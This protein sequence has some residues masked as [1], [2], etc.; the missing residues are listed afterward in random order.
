MVYNGMALRAP[1]LTRLRHLTGQVES[2]RR[3]GRRDRIT[4]F[5]GQP[6]RPRG[7]GEYSRTGQKTSRAMEGTQ[8]G[9]DPA[10]KKKGECTQ[11]SRIQKSN[12][13]RSPFIS[14]KSTIKFD[15]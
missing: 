14:K 8:A 3:R 2:G 9:E 4:P 11:V 12:M 15:P 1:Q 7:A 10:I 13:T 5:E 6:F